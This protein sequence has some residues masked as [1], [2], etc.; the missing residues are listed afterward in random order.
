MNRELIY[1]TC[2]VKCIDYSSCL[3]ICVFPV[4]PSEH[5]SSMTSP[6]DLLVQDHPAP[7]TTSF[8]SQSTSRGTTRAKEI[9]VLT[10][11]TRETH[12][13]IPQLHPEK[14]QDPTS[15]SHTGR[16]GKSLA[17]GYTEST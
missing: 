9:V 15:S 11:E 10:R 2:Y 1:A 13:Q 4:V 6:S 8:L 16:R 17:L 5:V 3:C 14:Q 7:F 12:R